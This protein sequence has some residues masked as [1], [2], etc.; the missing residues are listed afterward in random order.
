M[1]A[2]LASGSVVTV[3][4]TILDTTATIHLHIMVIMLLS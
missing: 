1:L 2:V 4:A 3:M